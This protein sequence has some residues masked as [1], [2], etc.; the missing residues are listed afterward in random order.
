VG[1]RLYRRRSRPSGLSSERLVSETVYYVM[2]VFVT[3]A[4]SA[5]A[6]CGDAFRA[7]PTDVSQ[8]ASRFLPTAFGA[9]LRLDPTNPPPHEK[10]RPWV[11]SIMKRRNTCP[12]LLG[13]GFQDDLQ[14]SCTRHCAEWSGPLMRGFRRISRRGVQGISTL[15]PL[16]LKSRA[17]FR[18]RNSYLRLPPHSTNATTNRDFVSQRRERILLN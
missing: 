13:I 15:R 17:Q 16:R 14:F 2:A 10:T 1:G 4:C 5:T 6:F 11:R 8:S 18:N 9:S 12:C 3:A 7:G